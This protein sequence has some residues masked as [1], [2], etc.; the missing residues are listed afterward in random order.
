V[1]EKHHIKDVAPSIDRAKGAE[2]QLP[3]RQMALEI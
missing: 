2:S 1:T 3:K